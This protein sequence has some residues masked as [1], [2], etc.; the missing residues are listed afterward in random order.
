MQNI[1]EEI[2]ANKRIEVEQA[3]LL[4][5]LDELKKAADSAPPVRSLR[6]SIESHHEGGI[7]AEFKRRSPSKDWINRHAKVEDIIPSYEKAGAAGL[8]ILT[9]HNY[10]GGSYQQTGI[11]ACRTC[12]VQL[13]GINHKLLAQY[14]QVGQASCLDH[15]L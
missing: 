8:S 3:K 7:I 13:V 15:I 11:C 14:G 4:V 9:D 5:T 12:L 1:L 10:F 2:V 6:K